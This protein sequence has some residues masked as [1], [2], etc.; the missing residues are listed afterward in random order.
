MGR[1]DYF[2]NVQGTIER[3]TTA[4]DN[5]EWQHLAKH[6]N[7]GN[8]YPR[9][10]SLLSREDATQF[11]IDYYNIIRD[12]LVKAISDN[13]TPQGN[14]IVKRAETSN[15]QNSEIGIEISHGDYNIRK[16]ITLSVG[17]VGQ[18]LL[19]VENGEENVPSYNSEIIIS[20]AGY[21]NDVKEQELQLQ[22][23]IYEKYP[24]LHEII[25]TG[26]EWDLLSEQDQ[27]VVRSNIRPVLT[28]V[29]DYTNQISYELSHVTHRVDGTYNWA[30]KNIYT[31]HNWEGDDLIKLITSLGN[32]DIPKQLEIEE[33]HQTIHRGVVEGLNSVGVGNKS[34]AEYFTETNQYIVKTH[35]NRVYLINTD[36]TNPI[37]Q[38]KT[39]TTVEGTSPQLLGD[40][41]ETTVLGG[42][43]QNNKETVDIE[44]YG[45]GTISI[46]RERSIITTTGRK[47][48]LGS[49]GVYK[50]IQQLYR[51]EQSKESPKGLGKLSK[52][53][54]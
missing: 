39:L 49:N 44:L 4:L 46:D 6:H 2:K 18:R 20:N 47:V 31:T 33:I 53:L 1:L 29:V 27:T 54:K 28:M 30:S 16:R 24:Q 45:L 19:Q 10:L 42:E 34:Y 12:A 3:L 25:L 14:Y 11:R 21:Y 13:L 51:Q 43:I 36:N 7:A 5:K 32:Q 41:S 38:V 22:S 37:Y 17:G 26:V 23:E 35:Y 52:F 40:Y 15:P 48:N 9:Y 50:L 8:H